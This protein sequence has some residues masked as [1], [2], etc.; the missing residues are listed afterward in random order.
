MKMIPSEVI[1]LYLVG[2]GVIPQPV[3]FALLAWSLVCLVAVVLVRSLGSRD[4]EKGAGPQW[5]SVA[6]SSMAFVIWLYSLGGVFAAFGV[7]VPYFGSLLVLAFTF[8]VP[9]IY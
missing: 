5:S 4:P 9:L 6:I 3:R 8:F 1:A 7:Y 2:A